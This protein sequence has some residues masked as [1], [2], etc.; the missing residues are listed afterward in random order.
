MNYF[1]IKNMFWPQGF[2]GRF[3][4]AVVGLCGFFL[5]HLVDL[6]IFMKWVDKSLIPI[7]FL[8]DPV[9]V[10]TEHQDALFNK[11][12][13]FIYILSSL[14]FVWVGLCMTINRLRDAG[15]SVFLS[16][17]FFL[18]ILNILY[19]LIL[20]LLPTNDQSQNS[21]ITENYLDR[22][23]PKSLWGA[24]AISSVIISIMS[25]LLVWTSASFFQKY[26]FMVFI[27]LPIFHGF[28]VTMMFCHHDYR[29]I[30]DCLSVTIISM[31]ITA[32]LM[33]VFAFEGVI[34]ILMAAPI[35]CFMGVFGAVIAF[36]I[37]NKVPNKSQTLSLVFLSFTLFPNFIWAESLI[38]F[39]PP[40]HKVVSS[41]E[42]QSSKQLVW[43]ELVAFSKIDEPDQL[44]F[45]A[46]IAYPTHATIKG[47]GVGA[48]RHC[49]FTTGE[50]IEPIKVWDEPNLLKFDVEKQPVPMSELS[51]YDDLDMPH[52]HGYFGSVQGQFLLKSLENGETYL[53]GT[54][55]YY[56]DIWPQFYWKAWS[57]YILHQIHYRVLNHIKNEAEKV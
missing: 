8:L 7:S 21:N 9:D 26:G 39:K 14:P 27:V 29:T 18:P 6:V 44:L 34:C 55:W 45:K 56:N 49:V 48:V 57:E 2:V 36:L 28:L 12:F 38:D 5:K 50:F 1:Q 4:Y 3:P 13:I 51:L 35:A 11:Q 32:V 16:L 20:T 46:G 52:L 37:Q 22:F 54:T 43:D 42:I 53:E 15:K 10:F 31:L 19:F 17:F 25:L 47:K 30:G 40:I 41:V 23:I 33:I 24:A